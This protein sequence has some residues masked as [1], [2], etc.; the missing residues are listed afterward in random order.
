[1]KSLKLNKNRKPRKYCL[2]QNNLPFPKRLLTMSASQESKFSGKTSH[3]NKAEIK[4]ALQEMELWRPQMAGWTLPELKEELKNALKP[5]GEPG[6]DIDKEIRRLARLKKADMMAEIQDQLVLDGSETR[7]KIL[8]MYRKVLEENLLQ[9]D[10]TPMGFG[11][12]AGKTFL[13]V[14]QLYPSYEGFCRDC[15]ESNPDQCCPEMVKFLAYLDGT[16]VQ[17]LRELGK[18]ETPASSQPSSSR[19]LGARPKAAPVNPRVKQEPQEIPVP[20]AKPKAKPTAVKA[21]FLVRNFN[22]STPPE[23]W[24]EVE[25]PDEN[26]EQDDLL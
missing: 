18:Q 1:M 21:G 2:A 23:G 15:W 8:S 4:V 12:Y 25:V 9:D 6:E 7:G 10:Y 20:K 5:L 3:Y 19:G 22:I 14:K 17:Q 16:T 24:M 11:K 26:E 13:E